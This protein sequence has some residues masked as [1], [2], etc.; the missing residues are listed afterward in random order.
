ML[1]KDGAF[2][3]IKYVKSTHLDAIDTLLKKELTKKERIFFPH[4]KESILEYLNTGKDYYYIVESY[5]K[6]AV[7]YGHMRTFNGKY[8]IP[9]LGIAVGKNARG[10]GI[11]KIL[12]EY[13][14]KDMK[15]KGFRRVM[16]KVNK[17]NKKA[18]KLYLKLGFVMY[19]WD[20]N[21]IWMIKEL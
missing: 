10:Y 4:N 18:F 15:R 3:K 19:N 6:N 12:C 13:M 8:N 7:A 2:Y 16:L 9:S 1:T 5:Y 21:F 14:I 11:G 20:S 17:E